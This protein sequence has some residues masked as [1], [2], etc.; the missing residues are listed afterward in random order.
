VLRDQFRQSAWDRLQVA[1][2]LAA[3]PDVD[4]DGA[5]DLDGRVWYSGH[6][7]GG[8]VGPQFLALSPD[9]GGAFLSVPGGKVA[10][11]VHR[12]GT[13][14]PL[15]GLMAPPGTSDG[16]LDR[17]F[18][19]LQ[20]AID[21][22]D[23]ASWAARAAQGRD[24]VATQVIDDGII[25]NETTRHLA[26]SL[27]L[28]HAGEVL[29]EVDGLPRYTGRYPVVANVGGHTAALWQYTEGHF[30]GVPSPVDHSTVW[31][32]DEHRAQLRAFFTALRDDGAGALIDPAAP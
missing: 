2:A 21:R 31:D 22:G 15:I 26:R 19:L 14:A 32:A 1:A 20:T 3:G 27:G 4:G 7:L 29:Q 30:D 28:E 25:P 24:V 23:P 5:P 16:Q 17:F 12:S 18:P 8:V 11:I 13:F 10:S 6:S 9:V